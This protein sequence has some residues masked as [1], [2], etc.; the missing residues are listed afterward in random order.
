MQRRRSPAP[1]QQA[2]DAHRRDHHDRDVGAQERAEAREQTERIAPVD[3]PVVIGE[4]EL[5]QPEHQRAT[6]GDLE[7]DQDVLAAGAEEHEQRRG[8]GRDPR[9]HSRAPHDQP[10]QGRRDEVQTDREQLVRQIGAQAE[11]AVEQAEHQRRERDQ[12]VSV[13][14]Q[15]VVEG[16][17][18]AGQ[19]VPLVAEDAEE[20]DLA[21]VDEVE[22]RAD[23]LGDG[24]H[25]QRGPG[26]RV[27]ATWS[28]QDVRKV[29]RRPVPR[30]PGRP[31]CGML[32][33]LIGHSKRA[34]F[35][36]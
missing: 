21:P 6:E 35:D 32:Y 24:E 18:A 2:R 9:A 26:R 14:Q 22:D 10:E 13:R 8:G 1:P 17:P 7:R 31:G 19:E 34:N 30:R 33:T 12:V 5:D 3:G 11:Q 29:I 23:H 15:Q 16:E 4:Q 25:D 20:P 36:D 28:T 27:V